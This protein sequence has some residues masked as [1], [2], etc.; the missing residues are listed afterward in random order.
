MPVR[1]A[2]DTRHRIASSLEGKVKNHPV[3]CIPPNIIPV[4]DNKGITACSSLFLSL[5][6]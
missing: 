2:E 1:T 5:E 3:Q 4:M 6:E